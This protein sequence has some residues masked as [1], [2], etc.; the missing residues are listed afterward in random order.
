MW[1][2]AAAIASRLWGLNDAFLLQTHNLSAHNIL[3]G[4]AA[5]LDLNTSKSL[6][7]SLVHFRHM[8]INIGVK[9]SPIV[10]HKYVR[11]DRSSGLELIPEGHFWSE[12]EAI[13]VIRSQVRVGLTM[14]SN[15]KLQPILGENAYRLTCKCL[16]ASKNMVVQRPH[17]M[18]TVHV[19]QLNI[20]DGR[21]GPAE[22]PL[23]D[24]F[25]Q[26][27]NEGV[28]LIGLC[29][30]NNW[31]KL[32]STTDVNKNVPL[33]EYYASQG[34]F[35]YSH[36]MVNS[37]P[38]NLGLISSVAFEIYGEYGQP[39]FQRGLLH[40]Y[41]NV[42]NLHVMVLHLHAQSS[43]LRTLECQ[44]VA[45]ILRPFIANNSRV[46]L[47]GD[48]NT[49]SPLDAKQHEEMELL[50]SL[51]RKTHEV[52]NR[53]AKKFLTLDQS[54]IDYTPMATLLATGMLDS[55]DV[56]CKIVAGNTN[57]NT[58]SMKDSSAFATCMQR[59][60][61]A[62]EPTKYSSEWPQLPNNEKHPFVRLDYILVSPAI[63]RDAEESHLGVL[64]GENFNAF[65]EVT[66]ATR[67]MS[68]HFPMEVRWAEKDGYDLF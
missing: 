59:Q 45:S 17:H 63:V 64:N 31:H 51:R 10:F 15:N 5:V 62:T 50:G 52:W 13:E 53:L 4:Q 66:N 48:M 29:E 37:Q 58:W 26:K 32:K 24:W 35:T 47:M 7:T 18:N 14:S 21:L 46:V 42:L 23:L 68:D 60:C 56:G 27:A 30:I 36:V 44:K 11:I 65:V 67:H 1:P 2:R 20:A 25:L 43:Q 49:L 33:I 61:A 28:L 34:G 9:A 55:C 40:V 3:Q 57:E 19:A 22:Y 54:K 39:E 16:T 6:L 12:Q 8:L 38:Y 41:V